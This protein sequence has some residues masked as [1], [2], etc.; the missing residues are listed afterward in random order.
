MIQAMGVKIVLVHGFRPRSTSNCA[1]R[2]RSRVTTTACESP[3]PL[4]W[5]APRKRPASCATRSKPPSAR[6][7]PTRPWPVRACA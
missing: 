3:T 7:C 2:A 1:S 4:R 6:D 5:T